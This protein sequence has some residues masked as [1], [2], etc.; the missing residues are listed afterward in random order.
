MPAAGGGYMVNPK[1]YGF[2]AFTLGSAG[3]VKPVTITNTHGINLTGYCIGKS[4]TDYLTIIN[5]THG[6]TADDAHVTV[7]PPATGPLAAE[8]MVL[9][10]ANPGD[11]TAT[12]VTLG[13]ATITGNQPWHGTWTPLA[14]NPQTGVSLTVR[15][16]TAAVVRIHT[17]SSPTTA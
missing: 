7:A 10:S 1:G 11:V 2:K 6:A 3:N 12:H 13:G 15:A 9:T 17:G 4:G 5:K 8:A 14:A 16:G